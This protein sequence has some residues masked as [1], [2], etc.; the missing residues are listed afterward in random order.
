ML[1]PTPSTPRL[2]RSKP[3]AT[4]LTAPS[5]AVP[6]DAS[7]ELLSILQ[8]QEIFAQFSEKT[9]RT[10]AAGSRKVTYRPGDY[11]SH[12]GD[13]R[14]TWGYIPLSGRL[15]ILKTSISGRELV[16]A[17]LAPGDLL[18]L[19]I[20]ISLSMLPLQLSTRAQS[21]TEVIA[22][23]TTVLMA[24]L[25]QYPQSYHLL[26]VEQIELLQSAYRLARGLA[27]DRVDIRIASVLLGLLPKF[28]RSRVPPGLT[29]IQITRQQIAD[30][31]G[32]TLESSIRTTRRMHAERMIDVSRPGI[33][34]LLDLEMLRAVEEGEREV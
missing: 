31:S 6:Q 24:A 5:L 7:S 12:E 11:I 26:L 4:K 1:P 15:A 16:V 34:H 17:L 10:V 14:G 23:D 28:S 2:G 25:D 21:Q 3:S 27:H 22:I 8:A 30:L 18:G 9:L 29:S 33:V 20:P 13:G 32:T 19:I